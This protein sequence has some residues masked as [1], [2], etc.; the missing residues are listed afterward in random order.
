MSEEST[1]IQ[2][3]K[4]SHNLRCRYHSLR[5]EACDIE[6]RNERLSE[7]RDL[8]IFDADYDFDPARFLTDAKIPKGQILQKLREACKDKS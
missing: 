4:I 1:Q 8:F 2:I 5:D 3:W 7:I 6:K